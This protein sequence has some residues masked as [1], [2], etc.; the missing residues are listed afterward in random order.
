M[1]TWSSAK[2]TFSIHFFP[3]SARS[4]LLPHPRFLSSAFCV[5][6]NPVSFLA[7]LPPSCPLFHLVSSVFLMLM[8]L[9]PAAT[10]LFFCI[11][12]PH[13]DLPFVFFLFS[14]SSAI[15]LA[16]VFYFLLHISVLFLRRDVL[17]ISSFIFLLFLSSLP[18]SFAL[19]NK[20]ST[21]MRSRWG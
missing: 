13:F 2:W 7:S 18:S 4:F 9:I 1:I 10:L 12:N 5:F 16:A 19:V 17:Q 3:L 21:R 20:K 11:S 8:A 14:S 15:A 6:F